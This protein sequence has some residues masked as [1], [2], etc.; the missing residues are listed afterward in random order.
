LS[1]L[2]EI[3]ADAVGDSFAL[4]DEF[5]GV[6]LG[7]DGFEDFVANGGE[8]SFVVVLTEILNPH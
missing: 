1:A 2:K 4:R 6:E 5:G 8:N 3:G 7:H